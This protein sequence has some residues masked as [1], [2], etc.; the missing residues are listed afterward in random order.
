MIPDLLKVNTELNILLFGHPVQVNYA[1]YWPNGPRKDNVEKMADP[2][3]SHLE[4]RSEKGII[5]ETGYLSHFFYTQIL[6]ESHYPTITAFLEEIGEYLARE[7]G[8][9]PIS[10]RNQLTL[11]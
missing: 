7:N 6:D 10:K 9:E 11:F 1:F 2:L 5:S 3:V 8:Y 4:F